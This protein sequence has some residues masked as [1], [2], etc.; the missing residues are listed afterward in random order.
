MNKRLLPSYHSP[1]PKTHTHM[2]IQYPELFSL[3][4]NRVLLYS[5]RQS[6]TV[7]PG[8][9]AREGQHPAS[10]LSFSPYL[11]QW[12]SLSDFSPCKF[13]ESFFSFRF[14]TTA[15]VQLSSLTDCCRTFPTGLSVSGIHPSQTTTTGLLFSLPCYNSSVTLYS[16]EDKVQGTTGILAAL[17]CTTSDS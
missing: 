2:Y 14:A 9:Q 17:S 6:G 3:S 8:I 7:H 16:L 10:L 11:I 1:H 13:L 15:L 12:L 4:L 5:C